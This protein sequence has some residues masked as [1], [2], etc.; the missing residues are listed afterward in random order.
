VKAKETKQIQG[1][2]SMRDNELKEEE[3]IMTPRKT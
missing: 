1:K 2:K 3:V